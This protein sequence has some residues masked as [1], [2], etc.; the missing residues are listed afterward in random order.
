MAAARRRAPEDRTFRR[1]GGRDVL[2]SRRAQ[3]RLLGA[4]DQADRFD[5]QAAR[6]ALQD[7]GEQGEGGLQ[8]RHTG[9]T[10]TADVGEEARRLG[11]VEFV[12]DVEC[13]ALLFLVVDV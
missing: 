3:R 4:A 10:E 12:M 5:L 7:A 13:R 8:A 2:R 9:E 6:D 11:C 1:E